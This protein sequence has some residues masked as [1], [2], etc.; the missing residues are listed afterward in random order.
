MEHFKILKLTFSGHPILHDTVGGEGLQFVSPSEEKNGIYS[1]VLI[2]PNGTGKSQILRLIADIIE[3]LKVRLSN[4]KADN[5]AT[6]A[7]FR[8]SYEMIVFNGS[9]SFLIQYKYS[10]A[11]GKKE[12]QRPIQK[13]EIIIFLYDLKK[14]E[15][16]GKPLPIDVLKEVFPNKLIALSYLISDK[17]R[18]ASRKDET[19]YTYLGIRDTPST[20]RTRTY[21][22]RVIQ[23]TINQII[24]SGDASFLTDVVEF[25]GYDPKYLVAQ[26]K[27]R[28][29]EH[30]FTGEITESKFTKLFNNWQEFSKREYES[31]GVKYFQANVK[32]DSKLITKVVSLLNDIST[33]KLFNL[34][35]SDWFRINL[36]DKRVW[37][38]F[39]EHLDTLIRLDLIERSSL[40]FKHKSSRSEE[41]AVEF[42][43]FSSGEFHLFSSYIALKS[44][45]VPGSLILIDEPEISLH[46]N[47]QMKYIHFLKKIFS[48]KE[49]KGCQVIIATHSHFVISDLKSETSEVL[50]LDRTQEGNV[51]ATPIK[52]N[53]YGMSAEGILFYIFG[54]R[55]SRN[56]YFEME[57]RGLLS[58]ISGREE[59][60]NVL[61]R[62]QE[63]KKHITNLSKYS[64][65]KNDPLNRILDQANEFVS[66]NS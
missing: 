3:D 11:P 14:E 5:S 26:Y 10:V 37:K 27:L 30:F 1:S 2:G 63:V 45:V 13:A 61:K 28:Y 62:V 6:K 20:A 8:F 23:Y 33:D 19:F 57:I 32:G 9:N 52:S 12:G 54:L 66:N 34:D 56:Y 43:D 36:L 25:I 7:S 21:S 65:G 39:L 48:G 51:A 15:V 55:T 41:N 24:Q 64:L 17:F 58:L 40:S 16:K 18:F 49:Y 50:K 29:K 4:S 22:N 38:K 35:E 46:P 31:F 47:W 59:E 60:E 53:T 44:T 42:Q